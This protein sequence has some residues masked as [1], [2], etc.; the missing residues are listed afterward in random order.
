MGTGAPS[1]CSDW[2]WISPVFR[3][4]LLHGLPGREICDFIYIVPY[5]D[6][7]AILKEFA[8]LEKTPNVPALDLPGLNIVET[9]RAF[10]RISVA[11]NTK[12]EIKEAF[13]AGPLPPTGPLHY[14]SS[15]R[16]STLPAGCRCR[17]AQ[18]NRGTDAF[19]TML[20][21]GAGRLVLFILSAASGASSSQVP[22]LV[23]PSTGWPI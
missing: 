9:A 17:L 13:K 2:R 18:R 11:A 8:I 19:T 23:K 12:D 16:T 4:E 15:R 14:G 21:I 20:K 7:Y 1:H 5:N 22:R 3:V 10:G 6:E